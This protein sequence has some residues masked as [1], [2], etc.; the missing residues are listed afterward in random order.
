MEDSMSKNKFKLKNVKIPMENHQTA[1][2]ADAEKLKTDSKVNIPNEVQVRN[3][4][5]YVETNQK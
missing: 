3:A 1:A 2:W 5:E 4:K